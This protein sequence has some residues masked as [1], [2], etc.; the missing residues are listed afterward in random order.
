MN[1]VAEFLDVSIYTENRMIKSITG[2][3]FQKYIH[4]IL[5]EC[6]RKLLSTTELS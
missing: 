4:N 3:N 2:E 6:A 5:F 1:D